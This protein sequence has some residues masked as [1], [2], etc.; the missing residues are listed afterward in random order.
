MRIIRT[1][2][3]TICT[4][5]AVVLAVL[6]IPAPKADR[7]EA[8]GAADAIAWG[9]DVSAWQG[10]IDWN[11]VKASGVQFVFI[12]CGGTI[13]GFDDHFAQNMAGAK[14]AGIKT[15]VYIYSYATNVNDGL[16]EAQWILN[17]V[18]PYVVEMP[19]VLDIENK[20]QSFLPGSRSCRL[21]SHGLLQ[22]KY[23]QDQDR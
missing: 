15:G 5:L 20:R 18:A 21:L 22:Q 7:V 1:I 23:V 6:S 8:K 16:I 11:A 10:N 14:A 19:L 4:L 12:K 2:K 9:I 3:V 13:Y 17:A